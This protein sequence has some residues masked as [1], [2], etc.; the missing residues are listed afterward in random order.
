M[1]TCA[2]EGGRY[3]CTD[4]TSFEAHFEP[5][6]MWAI[7]EPLY[8]F[9]VRNLPFAVR[10]DFLRMWKRSVCGL[11]SLAVKNMFDATLAGVRMSG[12]MNTS[13]GNGWANLVLFL[14]AMYEN[15]ATWDEIF[16]AAGFVEGDDG[17]F[18]ICE[19]L[20]PTSEQMESYGFC[21]KIDVVDNIEEASF[22]GLIFDPIDQVNVTDPIKVLMKLAWLPRRYIQCSDGLALELLKAKAQSALF[23]Y[24]GCPIITPVCSHIISTLSHVKRTKRTFNYF[25]AYEREIYLQS[26]GVQA[27]PVP[28]RTRALVAAT[29][30]L[31]TDMQH[32]ITNQILSVNLGCSFHLTLPSSY[33][34]YAECYEMYVS[35]PTEPCPARRR[36]YYDFLSRLYEFDG[37]S[38]P[39]PLTVFS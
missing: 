12:E 9:M 3:V 34:K 7:E 16:D 2:T 36:S 5:E 10:S 11:N 30:G 1:E 22:C 27:K 28:T 35:C 13:L 39:P 33:D 6:I 24:N 25:N 18:N 32:A 26:T 38:L 19:R 29:Y 4:Y 37:S 23:Q 20:S 15:G 14:F 17:I 21:L 31:T 8:K